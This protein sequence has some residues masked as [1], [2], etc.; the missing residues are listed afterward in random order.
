V[1]D[2]GDVAGDGVKHLECGHDLTGRVHG[3]LDPASG[4]NTNALGDALSR[5][6]RTW[7]PFRPRRDHAP[8]L[9]L[10][11]PDC[12]SGHNARCNGTSADSKSSSRRHDSL[13]VA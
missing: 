4:Q 3:D 7:Q 12:R 13:H 8:F 2:V 6:T 10:R 9:R 1:A 11:S 5:H